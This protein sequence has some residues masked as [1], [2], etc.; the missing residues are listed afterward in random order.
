MFY[1]SM[2][3]VR[4][5]QQLMFISDSCNRPITAYFAWD[6][7]AFSIESSAQKSHTVCRLQRKKV[8]LLF[9]VWNKESQKLLQFET[10]LL[11]DFWLMGCR[12]SLKLTMCG[13]GRQIGWGKLQHRNN[14]WFP[15]RFTSFRPE[16]DSPV[17]TVS[18]LISRRRLLHAA[19][20]SSWRLH[21]P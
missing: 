19:V 14:T 15:L 2:S 18:E 1:I 8:L 4:E 17:W 5:S 21:Y 20:P 16:M 10:T 13:E 12:S 6:C 7:F 9:L 3:R 11:S